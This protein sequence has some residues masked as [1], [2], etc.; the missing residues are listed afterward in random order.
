MII[1]VIYFLH[2]IFAVYILAK[3]FQNDGWLQAFLNIGFILTLFAVSLTVCELI[4]SAF[5]PETGYRITLPANQILLFFL[6]ISGFYSQQGVNVTLTPKDS[7]TL[8]LVT[9]V[10]I[11]FYRFYFR[12]T[13]V[14]KT[15]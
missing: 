9:I 14:T 12:K 4:V 10:E 8:S 3:S 11:F 2:T 7:V 15:A 1:A 5:I 13:Q 6:K